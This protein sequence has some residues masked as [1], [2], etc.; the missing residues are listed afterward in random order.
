V[1]LRR[2]CAFEAD[3]LDPPPDAGISSSAKSVIFLFFFPDFAPP[4]AA[5]SA[6]L[7]ACSR[8]FRLSPLAR[9][10][11]L[12][13]FFGG[14]IDFLLWEAYICPRTYRNPKK[15]YAK[16]YRGAPGAPR[17]AKRARGSAPGHPGR[18]HVEMRGLPGPIG[19]GARDPNR[20]LTRGAN[21]WTTERQVHLAL[22]LTL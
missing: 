4:L 22:T 11:E 10:P 12:S 19:C 5:K 1:L 18:G 7:F 13:A 6:A 2:F 16:T 14:G 8:A 9:L 17:R 15:T 20:A 21:I 3:E